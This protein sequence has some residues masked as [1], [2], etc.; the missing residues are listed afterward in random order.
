MSWCK[1]K[2]RFTLNN[3]YCI[4]NT[5]SDESG[6]LGSEGSLNWE[7]F[8]SKGNRFFLP[9]S[10]G[11]AWV[12]NQTTIYADVVLDDLIDFQSLHKDKLHIRSRAC[13][14]LLRENL[15]EIFPAPEVVTPSSPLTLIELTYSKTNTSDM[16]TERG[17]KLVR[18]ECVIGMKIKFECPCSSSWLPAR[19]APGCE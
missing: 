5:I 2:L 19:S 1:I 16:E 15:H 7:L 9:G 6:R 17:A 3:G 14:Q 13:P 18:I 12:N 8:S 4:T 10:L 11:P